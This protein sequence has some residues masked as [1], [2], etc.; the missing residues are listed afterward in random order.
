M[1]V[2]CLECLY[3]NSLSSVCVYDEEYRGAKVSFFVCFIRYE[4]SLYVSIYIVFT[5]HSPMEDP[6]LPD[7]G[8][9]RPPSSSP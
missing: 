2:V 7:R 8:P 4:K 9:S 3:F 6:V 1:Y 5:P